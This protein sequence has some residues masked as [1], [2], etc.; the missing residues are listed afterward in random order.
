MILPDTKMLIKKYNKIV[1]N[2]LTNLPVKDYNKYTA[3]DQ[4]TPFNG[5]CNKEGVIIE[6]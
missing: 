4:N 6:Y 2:V 3:A 5:T 1:S